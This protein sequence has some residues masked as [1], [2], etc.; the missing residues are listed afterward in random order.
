MI[1]KTIHYC[2]F[3]RGAKSKLA[4]KCLES[5]KR[6]CPD[7]EIIEWNEDNFDVNGCLYSRQAY[8]ERQFAF[9]ADYARL[10]I[11]TEHGGVYL[12]T[13][14]ELRKPIDDLLQYRFWAATENPSGN[15]V[16]I[17][18]GCGAEP[19]HEYFRGMLHDYEI[20]PFIKSDGS[21]DRTT[22]PLR[23][24]DFFRTVFNGDPAITQCIIV[25]GNLFLPRDWFNP[26]DGLSGFMLHESPNTRAIHWGAMSWCTPDEVKN[27]RRRHWKRIVYLLLGRMLGMQRLERIMKCLK[28]KR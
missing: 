28:M 11:M 17:G 9:V 13:D 12:D 22:G 26:L 1:P 2:H 3:G 16:C 23:N 24:T 20:I 27:F 8:A 14:V 15:L 25:N 7:F 10:K 5:W 4:L 18:L 6:F 19:E 21:Y